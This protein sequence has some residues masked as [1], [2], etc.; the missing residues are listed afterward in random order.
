MANNCGQIFLRLGF[1]GSAV[2]H[3]IA[4]WL[5]T[6]RY[7]CTRESEAISVRSHERCLV[8]AVPGRHS[9]KGWRAALPLA[10]DGPFSPQTDELVDRSGYQSGCLLPC[11][12]SPPRVPGSSPWPGERF[13]EKAAILPGSV[14]HMNGSPTTMFRSFLVLCLSSGFLHF[15]S[16]I[17]IPYRRP[18]ELIYCQ[19]TPSLKFAQVKAPRGGHLGSMRN[20]KFPGIIRLDGSCQNVLFLQR[21]G[22]RTSSCGIP[23]VMEGSL[24]KQASI[25]VEQQTTEPVTSDTDGVLTDPAITT[26]SPLGSVVTQVPV[27]RAGL[28]DRCDFPRM[29]GPISWPVFG[30]VVC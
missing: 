16:L 28:Q 6:E 11:S 27:I 21:T 29:H 13:V 10:R 9:V 5:C 14:W 2:E 23:R 26:N 4:E 12:S 7:T 20:V 18:S 19:R 8:S 15:V 3:G 1:M 24:Q 25:K 17:S 30:V 22:L